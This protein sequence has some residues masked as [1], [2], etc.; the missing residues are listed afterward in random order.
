MEYKT[1]EEYLNIPASERAERLGMSVAEVVE[2]DADV[3]AKIAE[4][5]ASGIDFSN[6]PEELNDLTKW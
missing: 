2:I 6:M 1:I 3:R 4:Q 5:K